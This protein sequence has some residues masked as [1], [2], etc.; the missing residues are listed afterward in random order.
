MFQK[1]EIKSELSGFNTNI[2]PALSFCRNFMYY[3]TF[4]LI[5]CNKVGGRG[6]KNQVC[7]LSELL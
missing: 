3:F 2:F 5:C 1:K 6:D 4:T 7:Q